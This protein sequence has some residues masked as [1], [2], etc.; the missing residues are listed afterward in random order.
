[1]KRIYFLKQ[2][3]IASA[4]FVGG[5]LVAQTP[6]QCNFVHVEKPLLNG[7]ALSAFPIYWESVVRAG[8]FNN[9]GYLD[10]FV[11]GASDGWAKKSD[12]YINNKNGT[13]TLVPETPFPGVTACTAIWLDYNNDG[14]LDLFIAGQT[15]QG[16]YAALWKNLGS[17][18]SY[19]FEE[20]C[21]GE[22]AP[23]NSEGG[24]RCTRYVAVA[25]YDNDG[26]ID[27]FLQGYSD[28]GRFSAVYKNIEGEGG[29]RK[30]E[31]IE[32]PVAG[33]KDFIQLNAGGCFFADFNNDGYLDLVSSGYSQKNDAIKEGEGEN[34]VIIGY[35]NPGWDFTGQ[36]NYSGY[37]YMNNGDGTFKDNPYH[38][39]G[40]EG[41]VVPLDFN[42][43]GNLD[44][45]VGGKGW[46]KY[47]DRWVR[48]VGDEGAGDWVDNQ[49]ELYI[50]N[51]DGTFTNITPAE[52][53][54]QPMNE[55]SWA[56]GDVNNDGFDDISGMSWQQNR[57]SYNAYGDGT[58]IESLL[59]FTYEKDKDGVKTVVTEPARTWGGSNLMF[60]FDRDGDL[61]II[62]CAYGDG[63]AMLLSRN[64][65]SEDV[66]EKNGLNQVPPAP[67]NVSASVVDSDVTISWNVVDADDHTPAEAMH[68]NI[69]IK[70]SDS[71]EVF[72]TLPVNI[73]DGVLKVS[74]IEHAIRISSHQLKGLVDG[75]YTY[76][77]Q[78]IDNGKLASVFATSQFTV[79]QSSTK[80]FN[81][82]TINV[83]SQ[84]GAVVISSNEAVSGTVN[85]YNVSGANVYS[86]NKVNNTI[87][88]PVGA[89][90]VK[91]T[92]AD[93]NIVKKVIVK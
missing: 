5:T 89:Y 76:G 18:N 68:Y 49:A 33:E 93:G 23:V 11:G 88:L 22:F 35:H 74:G 37:I 72:S 81:A 41:D 24:N 91:V 38:F 90:I 1:M 70:K 84:K 71:P 60:D 21:I 45:L 62:S 25:D 6:A 44:F 47:D 55:H 59:M 77:V 87:N 46:F 58:F 79:G 92:A 28:N 83:Y 31:K 36:D 85:I 52:S 4:L 86:A 48:P 82:N 65:L 80:S 56:I 27:I 51:G 54:L 7:S 12:L 63:S 30:F 66:I 13:F 9:D 14:N 20:V 50:G 67:S 17:D 8:D 32:K 57:I 75:T 69:Y 64:D 16:R 53:G 19:E 73:T 10:L 29:E 43:D 40:T 34:E 26:W 2:L 61:D 15:D 39:Y 3:L 42:N 78:A